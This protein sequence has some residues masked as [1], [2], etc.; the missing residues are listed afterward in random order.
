MRSFFIL[1]IG[2]VI[3]YVSRDYILSHRYALI[4]TQ[5]VLGEQKSA[6]NDAFISK[7]I[8]KDHA[9]SPGRII[10]RK[11]NYLTIT[12]LSESLMWLTSDNPQLTTPRGLGTSEQLRVKVNKEGTFTVRNTLQTKAQTVV[13]VLP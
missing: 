3:G 10:I 1:C 11:G 13:T 6:E 8:Y 7:I 4:I 12:N 2:L 9:F 5:S